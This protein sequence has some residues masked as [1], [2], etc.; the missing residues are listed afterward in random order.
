MKKFILIYL[1]ILLI[2]IKAADY[3]IIGYYPYWSIYQLPPENIKI[4]YI[5]H[6][7]YA[8]I[9]KVNDNGKIIISD[10]I[11]IPSLNNIIHDNNKKILISV[12]GWGGLINFSNIIKKQKLRQNFI[13]SIINFCI[14]YDFDGIDIDWEF[15]SSNSDKENL[16]LLIKELKSKINEEYPEL[17]L[18]M[19]IPNGGYY[20]Q[21]FDYEKLQEH[22]DWFNLMSYDYHGSWSS[23]SGHNAPLY[24]PSNCY[25]GSISQSIEYL[26]KQ[27]KLS[28]QKLV[29]G[30]P[31][32]GKKFNTDK[33]Y[34]SFSEC[35]GVL[36]RDIITYLNKGWKYN[37]DDIS[38]VPYLTNTSENALITYDDSLSI[39]IKTKYAIDNQLNGV[40]IWALNQ[41][42][43][44]SILLSSIYNTI[45]NNTSL[46]NKNIMAQ[47]IALKIFPNPCNKFCYISLNDY[48]Y[49]LL[50]INIYNIN[51]QNIFSKSYSALHSNIIKINFNNDISSG[52]YFLKL[53]IN[54][55]IFH[56][57]ITLIK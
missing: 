13:N 5:T 35:S 47:K 1:F 24:A 22:I 28:P 18:T 14:D 37:W 8:F 38:K 55:K 42:S 27:R 7:N 6:I 17:L 4:Q 30:V 10:N 49:N 26:I 31:F 43:D 34:T 44:N 21:W 48:K 52:I 25:D 16:T 57:K 33:L 54:N 23:H 9:E 45:T 20:G 11:I 32:Y 19:A 56:K 50:K 41:D 46:K 3:K 51:G 2:F 15:P 36:Y 39:A 12:G 53:Q 29:L 40:M